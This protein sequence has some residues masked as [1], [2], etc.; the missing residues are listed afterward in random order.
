[1]EKWGK[2]RIK[3]YKCSTISVPKLGRKVTNK[4]TWQLLSSLRVQGI[5]LLS[6]LTFTKKE[7]KRKE[8]LSNCYFHFTD[9]METQRNHQEVTTAIKCHILETSPV[10]L[11][12]KL[13]LIWLCK[14]VW[15]TCMSF[16]LLGA[17]FLQLVWIES[18]RATWLF[19]SMRQSI[20]LGQKTA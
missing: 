6:C 14:T 13:R 3:S 1:M 7:K 4:A 17:L 9:K 16:S 11:V 12:P 20:P 2:K 10:I 5:L 8:K 19:Q 15:K 18:Y